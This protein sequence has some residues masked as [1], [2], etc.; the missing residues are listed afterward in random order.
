MS[1]PVPTWLPGASEPPRLAGAR[2]ALRPV[3]HDDAAAVF[4]VFGNPRVM[5]YW[6]R[7]ALASIA[8]AQ[9]LVENIHDCFA[10][11]VLVQWAVVRPADDVLIGTCTLNA[12]E[13][14]HRRCEIG[15][16]LGAAYWGQGLAR[17]AVTLAIQFAFEALGLER[18][19]ADV[20]PRNAASLGLLERMGFK[21]EGLLRARWRVAGEVQDSAFYGLLRGE[22]EP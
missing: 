11:R 10:R 21:R 18:I 14:E 20:D 13:L 19:E 22:L 2:V 15:Y 9:A 3:R 8:E 5:R 16:A 6:S 1:E 17:E 7:P 12:I 4:A